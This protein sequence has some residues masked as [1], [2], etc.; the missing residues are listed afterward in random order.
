MK[1]LST[2]N[3]RTEDEIRDSAKLIL[4]EVW[5]QIRNFDPEFF[6]SSK[7][8]KMKRFFQEFKN[9]HIRNGET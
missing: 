7:R 4:G 5:L 8:T 9:E 6:N 1:K 2:M 3:Y